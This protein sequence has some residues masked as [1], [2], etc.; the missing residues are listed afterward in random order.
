[1]QDRLNKNNTDRINKFTVFLTAI[2]FIIGF[3]CA[4]IIALKSKSMPEYYDKLFILPLVFSLCV[5]CCFPV[6]NHFVENFGVMLLTALFLVRMCISPALIAISGIDETIKLNIE[7][8]TEKAIYLICYECVVVFVILFLI[9]KK[10]KSVVYLEK[11]QYMYTNER[12]KFYLLLFISAVLLLAFYC[13]DSHIFVGYRTIFQIKDPDFTSVEN[14][15]IVNQYGT[16]FVKK[17]ALVLSNYLIKAL[18]I[19][20]PCLIMERLSKS[21]NKVMAAGL[22]ICCVLSCFFIIDGAIARSFYYAV[23]LMF[24][25]VYL[26]SPKKM[27]W[28]ML[29]FFACGAVLVLMYWVL[30]Y[31]TGENKSIEGFFRYLSRSFSAYFS[32][33]NVVSGAFNLPK[34]IETQLHFFI[35]DYAKSIPLGNTLFGLTSE[36]VQPWFNEYN[37][38]QGQIP[39]TIGMGYY[40]FGVVF[41]PLYS[42]IFAV[43]SYKASRKSMQMGKALY[44]AVYLL[45]AFYCALGIIMYNISITIGN[46]IQ[47]VLPMLIVSR[48]I[49]GRENKENNS[50]LLVR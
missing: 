14:N 1:M 11:K 34:D 18:R 12:A 9:S 26:Y 50:L 27:M 28:K 36:E 22:S 16:T 38:S 42:V 5:L 32:G 3:A 2:L 17:L 37:M 23:I 19:I 39:P 40:Y 7:I 20:I 41:A 4:F 24:V 45:A 8:N 49:Y 15:Y 31:S 46:L 48:Y 30:R 43:L 25:F 29:I 6:L 13:M 21:K 47:I 10:D 44:F 35:Y 33:V